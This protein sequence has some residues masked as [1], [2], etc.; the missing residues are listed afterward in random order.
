MLVW[1]VDPYTGL[2]T[3]DCT[4]VGVGF[5]DQFFPN[6]NRIRV[7]SPGDV[8][9]SCEVYK[10]EPSAKITAHRTPT[11]VL[12]RSRMAYLQT[13]RYESWLLMVRDNGDRYVRLELI[14]VVGAEPGGNAPAFQA[15]DIHW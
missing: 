5:S 15:V 1:I 10:H 11:S 6:C 14:S 3:V 8:I 2:V 9:D 7:L 13:P 12:W 4:E